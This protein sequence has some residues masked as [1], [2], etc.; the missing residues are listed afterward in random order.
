[1]TEERVL[2]T[3]PVEL[4]QVVRVYSGKPGCG[5]G[6]RGKYWESGPMLKKVLK[7]VQEAHNTM[8]ANSVEDTRA[9]RIGVA[10]VGDG[11]KCAFVE[12]DVRFYWLY[13]KEAA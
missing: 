6:C 2:L 13:F 12:T 7:L 11:E 3:A 9:Y 4:K 1:M 5:C 8:V 10:D